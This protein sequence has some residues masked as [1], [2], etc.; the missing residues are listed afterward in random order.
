MTEE[1][2]FTKKIKNIINV[3]LKKMVS[4]VEWEL[5]MSIDNYNEIIC[6]AYSDKL[7]QCFQPLIALKLEKRNEEKF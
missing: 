2:Y 4:D 3:Y 7:F 5:L 1:E 6:N